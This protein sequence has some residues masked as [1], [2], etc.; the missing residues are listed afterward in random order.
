MLSICIE[1]SITSAWAFG[2]RAREGTHLPGCSQPYRG[3]LHE[4]SGGVVSHNKKTDRDKL[5]SPYYPIPRICWP[6][7]E[8]VPE[9]GQAPRTVAQA[10]C[11]ALIA[12]YNA[13][14]GA[15]W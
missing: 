13:T 4:E 10:D 3:E 7:P 14:G 12:L 11:K 1:C 2:R 9:V 8:D 5:H 15:T 6:A